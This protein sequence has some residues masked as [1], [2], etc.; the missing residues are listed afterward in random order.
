M[1]VASSNPPP[2]SCAEMS[3]KKKKKIETILYFFLIDLERQISEISSWTG[4]LE[5]VDMLAS[6]V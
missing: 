3:K 5:M 4:I 6:L 1:E 2:P